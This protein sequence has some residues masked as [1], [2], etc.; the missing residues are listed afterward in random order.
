[1]IKEIE[2]ISK[3][4]KDIY[5]ENDYLLWFNRFQHY[6]L[7]PYFK[8]ENGKHHLLKIIE[9]IKNDLDKNNSYTI[10]KAK[11]EQFKTSLQSEFGFEVKPYKDSPISVAEF[12]DSS[13]NFDLIADYRFLTFYSNENYQSF[14]NFLNKNFY[15]LQNFSLYEKKIISLKELKSF[16]IDE[17][18]DEITNE[19]SLD[20]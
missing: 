3:E 19:F 18:I 14:Y 12:R 4:F 2:K 7:T 8:L 9:I 20:R 13:N 16:Y 1:M 11:P 17:I 15:Y 10:L 6:I 5:K